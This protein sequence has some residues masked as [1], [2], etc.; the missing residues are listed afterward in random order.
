MLNF[1]LAAVVVLGFALI[2][3]WPVNRS[4]WDE[5]RAAVLA[6]IR[7][8]QPMASSF[9]IQREASFILG[10]RIGTKP[11]FVHLAGLERSGV[12]R[13]A[14]EMTDQYPRRRMYRIVS[15]SEG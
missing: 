4:R 11:L 3:A 12:V 9:R 2:V 8:T 5:N 15:P 1:I 7:S 14:W 10:R 6:A 13:S